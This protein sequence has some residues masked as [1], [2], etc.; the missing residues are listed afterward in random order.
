MEISWLELQASDLRAQADFYSN[1]L[2]LPIKLSPERLEVQAGETTLV[3]VQAGLE[4]NGAYHFAFNIPAN[5]LP[6]AKAWVAKRVPLL[7]DENGKDDFDSTNWNSHSVYFKDAAG[8]VLEFIARRNLKNPVEGGFDSSHILNVSEIGLPSEDVIGLADKLCATLGLSAFHQEPNESFTPVG[9]DNGLLI[10]PVKGRI[11]YP[12]SGVPA[13]ELPIHV[14]GDVDSGEFE[15]RGV[16][17]G[18]TNLT[19]AF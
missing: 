18:V 2:E 13:K 8:N 7:S 12:N 10:L 16:P 14:K 4:F 11:W 17:Y 1:I 3:F 9:D 5:Q 15:V 6:N 19:P